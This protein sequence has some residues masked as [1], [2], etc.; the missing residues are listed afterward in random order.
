MLF[1]L[2]TSKRYLES[3]EEAGYE[4]QSWIDQS[5]FNALKALWGATS[6]RNEQ[7]RLQKNGKNN[8]PD[9]YPLLM[10]EL[11][12]GYPKRGGRDWTPS[13]NDVILT[14][15]RTSGFRDMRFTYKNLRMR[16]VDVGGQRSERKKWI[17]LFADISSVLFVV[18]SSEYD[19]TMYEDGKTNRM[20]ESIE[21]FREI[22]NR[23]EFLDSGIVLFLNKFD[24]FDRKFR[25]DKVPLNDS[26]HFPKA[27]IQVSIFVS[28]S[29]DCNCFVQ[30]DTQ[31]DVEAALKFIKYQFLGCAPK[32]V[33]SSIRVHVT[34]ALETS[35]IV[36][37]VEL[38]HTNQNNW[39]VGSS[40]GCSR[41]QFTPEKHPTFRNFVT[42]A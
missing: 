34:N 36:S 23:P 30:C 20:F 40:C 32:G 1:L 5:T 28:H 4:Q 13:A 2:D 8:I 3:C 25:V 38:Y 42:S 17:H 10:G 16:L 37:E 14:R 31:Q 6:F 9:N 29:I 12:K 39:N 11:I 18:A 33:K 41:E 22:V 15:V 26:G 19:Q 24:L 27:P 7:N 35:Q 21:L